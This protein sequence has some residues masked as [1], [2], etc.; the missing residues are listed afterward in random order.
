M[1]RAVTASFVLT[2]LALPAPARA[3]DWVEIKTEGFTVY[4]DDG[5]K[6]ARKVAARLE[7]LR[8]FLQSEWPWARF[9]PDLPVVVVALESEQQFRLLLPAAFARSARVAGVTLLEGHR[10]LVLLH[11]EVREDPTEDN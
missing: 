9:A 8:G 4:G 1:L 10:T 11:G 6:A 2:C 7:A 3:G 5:E